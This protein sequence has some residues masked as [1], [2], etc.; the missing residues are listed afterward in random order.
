[1][2]LKGDQGRA[3]SPPSLAPSQIDGGGGS[4]QSLEPWEVERGRKREREKAQPERA[5]RVKSFRAAGSEPQ[6]Y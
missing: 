5:E 3:P 2:L 6:S 1:M 4:P